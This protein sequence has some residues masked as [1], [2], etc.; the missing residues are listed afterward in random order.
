[1]NVLNETVKIEIEERANFWL[2]LARE[3]EDSE[4]YEC[5]I[6]YV[7]GI[8]LENGKHHN[9]YGFYED[10]D[11]EQFFIFYNIKVV[12]K[13]GNSY[14]LECKGKN[15]KIETVDFENR[16][17]EDLPDETVFKINTLIEI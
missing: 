6:E 2:D 17:G 9:Y 16:H 1:M 5:L 11:L 15:Y 4:D 7:D 10:G 13:E 14:T 8:Y 12:S 3:L